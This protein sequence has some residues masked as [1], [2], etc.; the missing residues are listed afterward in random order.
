MREARGAG[1][2]R[3]DRQ[4]EILLAGGGIRYLKDR[5]GVLR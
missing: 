1:F 3:S 5:R 2:R 4:R